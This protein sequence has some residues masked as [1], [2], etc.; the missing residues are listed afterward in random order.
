MVKYTT[1]WVRKIIEPE[2]VLTFD[3]YLVS[4]KATK[5]AQFPVLTET[6]LK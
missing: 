4:L 6:L 5:F 1:S 3:T 2:T